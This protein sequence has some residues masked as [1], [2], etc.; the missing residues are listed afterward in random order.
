MMRACPAVAKP[1][2]EELNGRFAVVKNG[3]GAHCDM[4]LYLPKTVS[5]AM[6][7]CVSQGVFMAHGIRPQG[8]WSLEILPSG[9]VV[10]R[11]SCFPFP[12]PL[13]D[14]DSLEPSLVEMI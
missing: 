7:R 8:T 6:E 4:R 13:D 5:L 12:S 14:N 9:F 3:S 11:H 1:H 2:P 10:E